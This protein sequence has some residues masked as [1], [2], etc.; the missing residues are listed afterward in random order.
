AVGPPVGELVSG[1]LGCV[2][3]FATGVVPLVLWVVYAATHALVGSQVEAARLAGGERSVLRYTA[4][5][6]LPPALLAAGLG[7][8]LTLADPGPGQILD[9]WTAASELLTSFNLAIFQGYGPVGRQCL[10]LAGL[11]L[12]AAL[13]LA[14][15]TA[16][17][18]SG[19]MLA[20]PFRARRRVRH[21][22]V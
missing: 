13:P 16:P 2:L 15:L 12:A 21:R 14:L 8:V 4:G 10:V 22:G 5:Y 20:R 1:Y 9:L 6:A 7:G 3:V 19:E 18:L 11:A 17:G